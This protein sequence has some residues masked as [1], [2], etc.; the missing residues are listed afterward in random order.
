MFWCS[1]AP[2]YN[3]IAGKMR[4]NASYERH[5]SCTM[6]NRWGERPN[7]LLIRRVCYTTIRLLNPSPTK[8][9]RSQ[10]K[11]PNDVRESVPQEHLT[12]QQHNARHRVTRDITRRRYGVTCYRIVACRDTSW[13]MWHVGT[14]AG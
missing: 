7:P 9:L 1:L 5:H 14:L 3:K 12:R 8:L 2:D 4:R 13:I 10:S 11:L 6:L